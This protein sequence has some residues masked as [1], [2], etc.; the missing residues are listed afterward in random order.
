M[1]GLGRE[2][3]AR[4]GGLWGGEEGR[5]GR[6]RRGKESEGRGRGSGEPG[7]GGRRGSIP[8]AGPLQTDW[9]LVV[10]LSHKLLPNICPSPIGCDVGRTQNADWSG[11]RSP[12]ALS[13]W[14]G[15]TF[16]RGR[17]VFGV[18]VQAV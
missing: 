8:S 7:G 16:G 6:S 17:A 3:G 11:G 12:L 13:Q 1:E 14:E 5:G 9:R 10:K 18:F 2:G 4:K 15:R